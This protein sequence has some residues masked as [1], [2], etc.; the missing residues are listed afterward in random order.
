MVLIKVISRAFGKL[1]IASEPLTHGL[2]ASTQKSQLRKYVQGVLVP[3][4]K[5][6]SR[7]GKTN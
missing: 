5:K 7:K 1:L 2:G 4:G 6:E 3:S